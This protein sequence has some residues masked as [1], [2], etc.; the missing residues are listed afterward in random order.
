MFPFVLS[1]IVQRRA[2]LLI[3]AFLLACFSAQPQAT[4][5]SE[6]SGTDVEAGAAGMLP[7]PLGDFD[8]A[9][10]AVSA[11]GTEVCTRAPVTRQAPGETEPHGHHH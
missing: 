7:K 10:C 11:M 1:A 4:A 5:S 3:T 9:L 8:V 2:A 6:G